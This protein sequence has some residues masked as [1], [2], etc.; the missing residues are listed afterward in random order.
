MKAPVS[1]R[2]RPGPSFETLASQAPESL[3][4]KASKFSG[5][6]QTA[7][8][9]PQVGSE[10]PGEFGGCRAFEVF[11]EPPASAEPCKGPLDDPASW[12]EL[13][14]IDPVRTLDDLDRPRPAV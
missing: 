11:G 7:N 13:E 9:E 14:A 2:C 8:Y 1:L 6:S 10:E 12:Q 5:S 3:T 4:Q